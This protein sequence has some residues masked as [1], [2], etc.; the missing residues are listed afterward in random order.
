MSR[1]RLR[2]KL[3]TAGLTPGDAITNYVMAL[4]RML[5]EWGASVDVYADHIARNYRRSP[6]FHDSMSRPVAI[7]CG[8]NTPLLPIMWSGPLPARIIELWTITAFAHRSS[9]AGRTRTWSISAGPG[10]NDYRK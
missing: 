8:S 9:F 6:S 10:W 4:A 3:M 7:C 5:R 1:D 2:V